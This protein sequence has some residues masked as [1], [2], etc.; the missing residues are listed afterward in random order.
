MQRVHAL[1]LVD[2]DGKPLDRASL[3]AEAGAVSAKIEELK[4]RMLAGTLSPDDLDE[5]RTLD[6]TRRK[7]AEV[8]GV[9]TGGFVPDSARNTGGFVPDTA[10]KNKKGKGRKKR[11]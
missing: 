9:Y 2:A 11:R 6:A 5:L 7:L 10:K 1:G 3:L 8:A 4:P